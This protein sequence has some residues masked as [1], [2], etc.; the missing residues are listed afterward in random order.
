MFQAIAWLWL[1]LSVNG[2]DDRRVGKNGSTPGC[3]SVCF[4]ARLSVC[5]STCLSFVYLPIHLYTLLFVFSIVICPFDLTWIFKSISFLTCKHLKIILCYSSGG[6]D[7][8][9]KTA[10]SFVIFNLFWFHPR[11][12]VRFIKIS[13]GWNGGANSFHQLRCFKNH[14]HPIQGTLTEG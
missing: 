14:I 12:L 9:C 1:H 8:C 6:G 4:S 13:S 2:Q 10:K 5:V 11:D 3:L 7:E